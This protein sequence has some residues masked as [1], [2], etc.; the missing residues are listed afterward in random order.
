MLGLTNPALAQ[1]FMHRQALIIRI[2]GLRVRVLAFALLIVRP[3]ALKSRVG[4]PGRLC[5]RRL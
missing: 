1:A 3:L 5:R 4:L 2:S